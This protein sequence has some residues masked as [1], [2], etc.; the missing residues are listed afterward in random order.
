M[1]VDVADSVLYEAREAGRIADAEQLADV[2]PKTQVTDR[3]PGRRAC[4]ALV[5][6]ESA[7]AQ[8]GICRCVNVDMCTFHAVRS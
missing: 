1:L 4:G 2:S 7:H 8:C 6:D 3:E 5:P